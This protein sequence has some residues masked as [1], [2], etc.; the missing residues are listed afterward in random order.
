MHG[1]APDARDTLSFLHSITLDK[2][3]VDV[4]WNAGL[5]AESARRGRLDC[6][7]YLRENG[8]PWDERTIIGSLNHRHL[9]CLTYA[10]EHGCYTGNL[11]SDRPTNKKA[12]SVCDYAAEYNYLD[13]LC[14]IV[15]YCV[16]SNLNIPWS[17]RTCAYAAKHSDL[18]CLKYLRENGCGW[19]VRTAKYAVKAGNL[20]GLRYAFENGCDCNI[21]KGLSV[22]P[23]NRYSPRQPISPDQRCPKLIYAQKS[24]VEYLNQQSC[25]LPGR[26]LSRWIQQSSYERHGLSPNKLFQLDCWV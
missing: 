18:I 1:N 2:H 24:C 3:G 11:G 20:A 26:L 7:V 14:E 16:R 21:R 19:D 22:V 5:C 17:E 13:G 12:K 8:C 25:I 4:N 15:D 6:L 23:I 10:L 9:D